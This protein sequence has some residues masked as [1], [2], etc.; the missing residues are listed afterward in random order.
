MKVNRKKKEDRKRETTR[1]A[2]VISSK[3]T[4]TSRQIVECVLGIFRRLIALGAL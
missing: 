2:A 3:R 4:V 1:R